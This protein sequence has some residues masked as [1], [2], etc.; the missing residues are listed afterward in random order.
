LREQVIAKSGLVRTLALA[1]G[2]HS[3]ELF[4]S[5]ARGEERPESDIDLLVELDRGRSLLDLIALGNDLEE[6]FGRRVDVIEK[7][8]AKARV[9]ESARRDGVKLL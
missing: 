3:V 9:R 2:A 1:H 8:A 4:G 6:A 5:A 7:S